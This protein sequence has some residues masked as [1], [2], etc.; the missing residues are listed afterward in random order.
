VVAMGPPLTV[1]RKASTERECDAQCLWAQLPRRPWL[2]SL[3]VSNPALPG[4]SPAQ[5]LARTQ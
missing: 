2:G 4:V 1:S 5:E 3:K